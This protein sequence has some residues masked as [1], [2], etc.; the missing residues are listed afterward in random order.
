MTSEY[1]RFVL[2]SYNL[3]YSN[4]WLYL[5]CHPFRCRILP[6]IK[7]HFVTYCWQTNLSYQAAHLFP[8]SLLA[9]HPSRAFFSLYHLLH[10]LH[11]SVY[12]WL[13][14]LLFALLST[15]WLFFVCSWLMPPFSS[16]SLL[17]RQWIMSIKIDSDKPTVYLSLSFH[18]SSSVRFRSALPDVALR[19]HKT[20]TSS[21]YFYLHPLPS[22]TPHSLFTL[23]LHSLVTTCS[24]TPVQPSSCSYDF[25]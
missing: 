12:F 8:P 1:S 7:H 10:A 13:K 16:F 21:T 23:R 20:C 25:L 4:V 18:K 11:L 14:S 24:Y 17:S 22:R 3:I 19:F 5:N 15:S 9:L 2:T 6:L